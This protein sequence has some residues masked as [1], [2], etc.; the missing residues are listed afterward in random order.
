MRHVRVLIPVIA[1]LTIP[2][3]SGLLDAASAG[4]AT[5]TGRPVFTNGNGMEGIAAT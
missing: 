2:S 5:I 1:G 3:G 4:A